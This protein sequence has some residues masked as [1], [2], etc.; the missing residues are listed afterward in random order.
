MVVALSSLTRQVSVTRSPSKPQVFFAG[1]HVVRKMHFGKN[2]SD[3]RSTTS[4]CPTPPKR[5]RNRE[6]RGDN[7][8][9]TSGRCKR[10]I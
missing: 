2:G 9:G 3:R 6:R 4:V 1:H 5:K 8:P 7:R 10:W